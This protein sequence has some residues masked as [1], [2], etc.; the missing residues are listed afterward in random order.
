MLCSNFSLCM[1]CVQASARSIC[2]L[3]RADDSRAKG[4]EAWIE[5]ESVQGHG[6]EALA[7]GPGESLSPAAHI[8]M[9]PQAA[10]IFVSLHLLVLR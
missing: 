6:V 8:V 3:L 4:R 5:A 2:S 1:A 10:L 7:E 9:I